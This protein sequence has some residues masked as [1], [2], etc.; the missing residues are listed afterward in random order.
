MTRPFP[1]LALQDANTAMQC[2]YLGSAS[3]VV[4]KNNALWVREY[5]VTGFT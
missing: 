3:S 4:Q 2:H 5:N 1:N